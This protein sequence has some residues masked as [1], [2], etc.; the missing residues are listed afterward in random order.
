ML[1][2]CPEIAHLF[3]LITGKTITR[4]ISYRTRGGWCNSPYSRLFTWERY[5]H[6][7]E[8]LIQIGHGQN[9]FHVTPLEQTCPSKTLDL[10][11]FSRSHRSLLRPQYSLWQGFPTRGPRA[12]WGLRGNFVR[13]AKSNLFILIWIKETMKPK[14]DILVQFIHCGC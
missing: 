4:G 1:Y 2:S 14:C 8:G 11:W 10:T 6:D 9:I 5:K 12:A 3:A 13:P 7:K